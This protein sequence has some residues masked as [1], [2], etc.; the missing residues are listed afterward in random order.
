MSLALDKSTIIRS[1]NETG[2]TSGDNLLV[3]SAMRTVG[4]IEGGAQTMVDAL[5]EVVGE[6]GTLIVPTFTF[7]H[8]VEDDPI[9][10]PRLDRSEMGAISEAARTRPEALRSVAFRHSFAAIGRR[11]RVITEVDPA[12]SVFDLRSS[13]GMMLGLNTQVLMLGMGYSSSTSHHFAEWMCEVPYRHTIDLKVKIRRSDDSLVT[14]AMLDYQ[15]QSYTGSRHTD[16]N[17][18]GS[19]L[20]Q[21]GKVG[22]GLIGNAVA[23]RYALRDLIDLAQVEAEKDYNVFRTSEGQGDD[24]TPLEF[25]TIV[26]SPEMLDGAGRASRYQW[27]VGDESKL[28]LPPAS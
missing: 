28:A 13:F 22:V 14:Q 9:I 4:R 2:I 12:L 18:L 15:P 6:R 25:G 1:L 8:E 24:F 19:M 11:A 10:A 21:Q 5:L 3:H 23:R 7:I 16:F 26:L 27:C 20:E 17:R